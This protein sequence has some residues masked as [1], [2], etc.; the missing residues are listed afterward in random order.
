[1]RVSMVN[2]L[3]NAGCFKLHTCSQLIRESEYIRLSCDYKMINAMY[4]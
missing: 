4:H 3:L 1:M 2:V